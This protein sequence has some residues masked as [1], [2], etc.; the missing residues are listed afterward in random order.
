MNQLTEF[1][2]IYFT[3]YPNTLEEIGINPN[4]VMITKLIPMHP[5]IDY[6]WD[7]EDEFYN[8]YI[9]YIKD[10][11]NY[12]STEDAKELV[13]KLFYLFYETMQI[14]LDNIRIDVDIAWEYY[15]LKTV[16]NFYNGLIR[17]KDFLNISEPYLIYRDEDESDYIDNKLKI[18]IELILHN[19]LYGIQ[20]K[21]NSYLNTQQS[22]KTKHH[23]CMDK[24]IRD[25]G[26]Q[27]YYLIFNANNKPMKNRK[28][29]AYFI[30]YK[31]ILKTTYR[32]LINGSIE[33]L[34]QYIISLDNNDIM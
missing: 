5:L 30:Y 4:E 18:D 29:G 21:S 26:G 25:Y 22:L 12:D 1:N 8:A 20:I 3:T 34:K 28:T 31:D 33:D 11:F 19:E 27:P 10:Y 17:E 23:Y 13:A 32:D 7:N 15:Y 6:E 2:K 24:Y 14:E 16:G 9:L